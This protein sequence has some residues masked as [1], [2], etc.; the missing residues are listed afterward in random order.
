MDLSAPAETVCAG[1]VL[2]AADKTMGVG[3]ALEI[4]GGME[5]FPSGITRLL[6]DRKSTRLNSSHRSLS[7]MPSSA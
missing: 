5:I 3:A 1:S 6:V 7:R 4:G 2:L